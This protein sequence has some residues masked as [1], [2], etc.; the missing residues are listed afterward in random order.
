MGTQLCHTHIHTQTSQA[1]Q[2]S[3]QAPLLFAV[4]NIT[5]FVSTSIQYYFEMNATGRA[6][7]S[8]T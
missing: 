5:F 4:S 7:E 3:A 1:Q 8:V 6:L 2:N